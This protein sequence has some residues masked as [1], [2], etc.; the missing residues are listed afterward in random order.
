GLSIA[1]MKRANEEATCRRPALDRGIDEIWGV[2]SAC[3][4]RGI[5]QDGVMPGG[6]NV[7]RRARGIF[8]QLDAQWRRNAASTWR[9][10]DWLTLHA[11][12]V[13]EKTAGGGPVATTPTA[14][15][16]GVPPAVM[17]YFLKFSAAAGR[18]SVRD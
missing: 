13:T 6:L 4:D 3:I 16:A 7:K 9:A 18:Q 1:A 17:K 14:G 12:D 15:S 10:K 11:Q 8:T 2:M 5:S